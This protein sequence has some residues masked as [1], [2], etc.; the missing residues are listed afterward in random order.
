MVCT[1]TV[2]YKCMS[3]S[4]VTASGPPAS[5][6]LFP[7]F[8]LGRFGHRLHRLEGSGSVVVRHAETQVSSAFECYPHGPE[9]PAWR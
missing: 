4:H 9:V 5:D 2:G 7:A 6:T 8:R 3:G 1:F